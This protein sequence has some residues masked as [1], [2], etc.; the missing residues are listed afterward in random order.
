LGSTG[1]FTVDLCLIA[2]LPPEPTLWEEI[3]KYAWIISSVACGLGFVVFVHELGHFLVAKFCGVKCEKFYVGFDWFPIERIG[4]FKIPRALFR[5]QWGE[6]EY[7]IGIL[8]L[9]GYV[10]MLG[11]DDDPRNAEAEAE[12]TKVRVEGTAAEGTPGETIEGKDGKYVLDPRSYPAKAVWQ[13]MAIISAGVIM[14]LIFGVLL[15]SLAYYLGVP[16]TPAIIG[17]TMPGSPA[18]EKLMPGEQAIRFGDKGST[19]EYHRFD[20]IKRRVVFAGA[21]KEMKIL[22]RDLDGKENMKS[23]KPSGRALKEADF[24]SL[25]F[26][27][28]NGRTLAAL[29][30]A[31]PPHKEI[32]DHDVV[33]KMN[34]VELEKD[35][36]KFDRRVNAILAQNPSGDLKLTLERPVKDKNG[37]VIKDAPPEVLE[38]V[39]PERG[40]KTI[41]LV[42]KIGPVTALRENSPA[43]KA[44]M[45]VGDVIESINGEPL[46]DPLSLSQRWIP[47]SAS[48]PYK[49]VV[50]RKAGNKTVTKE[51]EVAAVP[52]EQTVLDGFTYGGPTAIESM[53]VAFDVTNQIVGVE[54]GTPAAGEDVKAGDIVKSIKFVAASPESRA[55]E[56]ERIGERKLF[57]KLYDT[58]SPLDSETWGWTR[59]H[60]HLQTLADKGTKIELTL[61][62]DGKDVKVTMLPAES[63]TFFEEDRGLTFYGIKVNH[64]ASGMGDAFGLGF[65]EVKERLGDVA[66]TLIKLVGGGIHPKHLSGPIGI[67]GAAGTFANSGFPMLLLFLTMLSANLAIINFLPIPVLDGGHMLF[68]AAEGIRRKPVSPF[69]QNWLSIGGLAFLLSLM[70]F[71]TVMDVQRFFP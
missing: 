64:Q 35:P 13:R 57:A 46:G 25:G 59:V 14:N 45:Q 54:P 28:P 42:M 58:G 34:G 68:L 71:A 6:T 40:K 32:E 30:E 17:G 9:G 66:T 52:P 60:Y 62:R 51:L 2:S 12:R 36:E 44:G 8:P 7:G 69:I 70:L 19:Y 39:V 21:D 41:G 38:V 27:G 5:K 29:K 47:K 1:D 18:W 26:Y 53:G 43:L 23:L 11:Q 50:S 22:F 37:K 10:K 15:G 61:D 48:E 4:P 65:R 24:P 16:E 31:P 3:W 20:D 63:K 49:V 56:S 55:K 67:M 33:V